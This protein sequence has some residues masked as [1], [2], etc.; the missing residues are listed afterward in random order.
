M[1]SFLCTDDRMMREVEGVHDTHPLPGVIDRA[2]DAYRMIRRTWERDTYLLC[3]WWVWRECDDGVLRFNLLGLVAYAYGWVPEPGTN[4]QH[5]RIS[6]ASRH[7]MRDYDH[8][9]GM[10][11][12]IVDEAAWK[13]GINH[14]AP[15][16]QFVNAID[17]VRRGDYTLAGELYYRRCRRPLPMGRTSGRKIYRLG[18]E[19][20][21]SPSLLISRLDRDLPQL[22]PVDMRYLDRV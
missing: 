8:R 7:H 6:E 17:A 10:G 4:T 15:I 22:G 16:H 9:R 12:D 14:E 18:D 20:A 13:L 19:S 1:T 11:K 3:P 2:L 5:V 21:V